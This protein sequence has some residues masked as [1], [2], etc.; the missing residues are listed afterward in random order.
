[1]RWVLAA[2][3]VLASMTA[4]AC[5]G[6][7]GGAA[8]TQPAASTPS[9]TI[10][11]PAAPD[12]MVPP[13][14]TQSPRASVV[15]DWVEFADDATGVSAALPDGAEAIANSIPGP[16]GVTFQSRGYVFE[17]GDGVLGFEVIEE[18]ATVDD[19]RKLAELLAGSVGGTVGTVGEITAGS[20]TGVDGEI[21]YGD[22][23]LML[24]RVLVLN[25][26]RDVWNGF[27][28]GPAT[29]RSR[30]ES[31]FARLTL[32]ADLERATD[33]VPV[34]DE[35]S[36]IVVDLPEEPERRGL[37]GSVREYYTSTPSAGFEVADG[38]L[39]EAGLEAAL[40]AMAPR[41]DG[42][43]QESAPFDLLGYPGAEGEIRAGDA[44]YLMRVVA[45]EDHVLTLLV[46]GHHSYR[47]FIEERMEQVTDSVVLP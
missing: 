34:T 28:G 9:S 3:T 13:P 39:D 22:D 4:T 18:F 35:P 45:V 16:D 29:D 25:D 37:S 7:D 23:E 31:E 14:V 27:V 47:S 46:A 43:V 21:A 41:V 32:S 42:T 40:E 10:G 44:L 1:M 20:A 2:L 17:H 11:V 24:F 12:G 19:L 6:G 15:F 30:L 36:G 8:D 26:N 38:W 5:A 33:W